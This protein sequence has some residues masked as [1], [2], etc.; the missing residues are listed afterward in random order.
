MGKY[1]WVTARLLAMFFLVDT[2]HMHL[3]FLHQIRAIDEL[4]C[5]FESNFRAV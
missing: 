1:C 3:I 5:V 4:F 2:R